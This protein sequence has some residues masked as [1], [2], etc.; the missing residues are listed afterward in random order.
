MRPMPM[1][2]SAASGQPW[3]ILVAPDHETPLELRSHE[4]EPVPFAMMG[5]GLITAH[6][7]GQ[8][9]EVSARK[10][11]MHVAVGHELMEYFLKR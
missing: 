2:T 1:A 11:G 8:F 4:R 10:T 6:A 3:R 5:D 7:A 9:T